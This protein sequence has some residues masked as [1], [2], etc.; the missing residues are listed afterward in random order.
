MKPILPFLEI[1]LS[2]VCNLVCQGCSTYSDV[3]SR[4]YVPWTTL[5]QSLQQWKNRIVVQDIGP[6]GGEP[7]IYPDV[8][9]MLHDLRILFPTSKIRF[10][11]NGTLLHKHWDV[12]DWLYRDGNATLKITRHITDPTL[13]ENIEHVRSRYRWFPVHEF[14]IDRW[15]TD[16]GL[17][18]QINTPKTFTQTFRGTYDTAKP[19]Y[20]SPAEAFDNCHQPTCPLLHNDRIYKCSTS[21]LLRDV[22]AK[23]GN[24]NHS[25]WYPYFDHAADGSI[26]LDS[27][28]LDIKQFADNFGC[29]HSICSQCPSQHHDCT[30]DHSQLVQFR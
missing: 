18:L 17:R 13:E 2:S 30:V 12:V 9:D 16:T 20:S 28:D 10:P 21:A 27:T 11:T 4:G 8:L 29:P 14:G 19:W 26:G 25:L 6:M 15:R 5:K 23:H 24:P 1:M 7:L 3:P 22:L